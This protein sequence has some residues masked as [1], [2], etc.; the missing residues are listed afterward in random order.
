MSPKLPAKQEYYRDSKEAPLPDS[1]GHAIGS[2][3]SHYA[4]ALQSWLV[5]PFLRELL[6]FRTLR[7]NKFLPPFCRPLNIPIQ[8]SEFLHRW[9]SLEKFKE[10]LQKNNPTCLWTIFLILLTAHVLLHQKG[11][12]WSLGI[13]TRNPPGSD[14]VHSPFPNSVVSILSQEQESTWPI[15]K[16]QESMTEDSFI[17]VEGHLKWNASQ[18]CPQN[19]SSKITLHLTQP[20]LMLS[21]TSLQCPSTASEATHG[22]QAFSP[23]AQLLRHGSLEVTI[24]E[25]MKEFDIIHNAVLHNPKR[26]EMCSSVLKLELKDLRWQALATVSYPWNA[27]FWWELEI[28]SP[29]L[30]GEHIAG[31]PVSCKSA[32]SLLTAS[33]DTKRIVQQ[34]S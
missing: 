5:L 32:N 26:E 23:A 14:F 21:P 31:V 22:I 9:E 8:V 24:Q 27:W 34:K 1:I 2:D 17:L 16:P 13:T 25:R 10:G 28:L 6:L 4:Q 29:R 33:T 18:G 11:H 30:T 19:V 20:S 7:F 12:S 3:G 15:Y